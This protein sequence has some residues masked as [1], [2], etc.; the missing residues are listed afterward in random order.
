M[1]L[2]AKLVIVAMLTPFDRV[3]VSKIS[4]GTIQLRGPQAKL[5]EILKSQVLQIC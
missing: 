5:K 3:N 1:V 4:A 2:K